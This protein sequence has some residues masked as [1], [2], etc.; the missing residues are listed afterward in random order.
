MIFTLRNVCSKLVRF[1]RISTQIRLRHKS[2]GA[3]S[4]SHHPRSGSREGG[5]TH[6]GKRDVAIPPQIGLYDEPDE[7]SRKILDDR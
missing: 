4:S 5:N 7:E 3:A 2:I 6:H 1:S